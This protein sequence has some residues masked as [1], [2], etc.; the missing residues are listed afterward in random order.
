[1]G[2]L[3]VGIFWDCCLCRLFF[4]MGCWRMFGGRPIFPPRGDGL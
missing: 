3:M 1:M 2:G 4:R